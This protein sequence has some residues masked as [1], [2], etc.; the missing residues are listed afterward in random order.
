MLDD[1]TFMAGWLRNKLIVRLFIA[2][3]SGVL[4]GDGT[5]TNLNGVITQATAWAAGNFA[6]TVDLANDVDSLVVGKTQI[7]TA[8][9]NTGNLTIMMHPEDVAA[10]LLTK[11]SATDGRYNDRL[12][13]VAGNLNLDGTPIIENNDITAGDFLIAD[14]SK[15]LIAQ[16]SGITVEVG[17][18]GNDF[19][20]NMR[21][22][23]AEWRGEVIIENNDTTAFVTGTFATTNAALETT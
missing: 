17:L 9:Q 13:M 22:I 11:L 14:F 18:D 10:L 16:K 20:K 3:D 8:N 19:T 1:I 15:A 21:T 7:K 4:D 12:M 5:G 2:I 6:A 23:I